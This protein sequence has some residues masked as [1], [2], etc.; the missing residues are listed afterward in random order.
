M[1]KLQTELNQHGRRYLRF[2]VR[3]R[4]GD[5]VN[6]NW[7]FWGRSNVDHVRRYMLAPLVSKRHGLNGQRIERR[8]EAKWWY[9]PPVGL[10]TFRAVFAPLHRHYNEDRYYAGQAAIRAGRAAAK[11]RYKP[12]YTRASMSTRD[13]LDEE[14]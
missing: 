1:D 4:R 8:L 2:L 7:R 13:W 10:R 9:M 3:N 6:F 5:Y 14:T 11:L 12:K